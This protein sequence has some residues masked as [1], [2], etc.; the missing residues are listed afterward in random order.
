MGWGGLQPRSQ[1]RKR[2]T[3]LSYFSTSDASPATTLN[4]T[5]TPSAAPI[6]IHDPLGAPTEATIT[7]SAPPT[8]TTSP[9]DLASLERDPGL[10]RPIWMYPPNVR[11][12][13]R[14]EYIRLGACQPKL[15]KDQYPSTEFGNQRRRFQA[16]WFNFMALAKDLSSQHAFTIDGFKNWKRVNDNERC[17]FFVHIKGKYSP[18]KKAVKSLEGLTDVTRHIDKVINRQSLEEIKKNRLCLRATIE[19]VRYLSLQAC[20]LR[21]HDESST[22]RNRGNLIEMIKVFGRLSLDISNIVLEKVPKNAMYTSPKVQKDILH[23]LATKV[24]NKI[25]DELGDS[26][27]CILVDEAI[28]ASHKEQMAIV[29][30]FVDVHGFIRERFFDIVNVADTISLTLKKEIYDVLTRNNL[31]I[32]NMR[33]Q[34]YD[35][36]TLVG[37]AEKQDS[38]WEFFSMLSNI[39][40]IVTGS[41]KRLR[42]LQDAHG[43]EV[44]NS[45]A[46]EESETDLLCRALQSKSIDILNA[47]DSVATTIELLQSLRNEGF[48]ILLDYVM[49]V[50]AKYKID[51]PDM[52][53]RYMD[54]IRSVRQRDDISVE[55][56]YHYDVFNSAIDFQ[57]E[58]LHYRFNDTAVQLLRLSSS[59]EPKNNFMMFDIEHIYT[60]ATSFYPADFGQQEIL[61]LKL[62]LDHYKIDVVKH[63]KFQDLSTISELCLRLVDTEKAEQYTTTER[64]FSIMKFVK[65][66][67]RNK[68]EEEYLRDSMLINI[69]REYA[70][71][72]DPDEVIDEFYAQKNRRV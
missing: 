58:E 8:V 3:L 70:E 6:S 23:I 12:D 10:R 44:E 26:K 67:L 55:H 53:A 25:R 18:H 27:Y 64:V 36:A 5:T 28:D 17:P 9:I 4:A 37:A 61:H 41:S 49:S 30:Q 65:T 21:G 13:I 71:D 40:N 54:G 35:G 56:H 52:N 11:D 34:G 24:R 19:A 62:Q 7:P 50:C 51:V 46:S 22:S 66:D 20:A 45:V 33:G 42:E 2:K 43:I 32:H 48:E 60:L 59:L 38:I 68:M 15:K 14:R 69:E 16:Y 1:G 29:L 72:I 39:V 57:L 63:A 47:M 31:S